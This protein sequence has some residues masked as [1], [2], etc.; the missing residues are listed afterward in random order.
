MLQC[1][2]KFPFEALRRHGG[3]QTVRMQSVR[4]RVEHIAAFT[5]YPLLTYTAY[6][7]AIKSIKAIL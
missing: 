6:K 7:S 3:Q 2:W 4:N 1:F 5:F